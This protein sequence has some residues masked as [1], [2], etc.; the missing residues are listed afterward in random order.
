MKPGTTFFPV[1]SMT[2]APPRAAVLSTK[3]SPIAKMRSPEIRISARPSG[4]RRED[5]AASNHREECVVSHRGHA[6]IRLHVV[7]YGSP[8]VGG[9]A[10]AAP[11]RERS[12]DDLDARENDDRND[13]EQ[14][15]D[16]RQR[17]IDLVAHALP[18]PLGSVVVAGPAE[19]DRQH[20]LVE[21]NEEG[22]R[23]PRDHRGQDGGQRDVPERPEVAGAQAPRG[24]LDGRIG[25]LERRRDDHDHE[26][27]RH[28]GVARG[29][30]RAA[31]PPA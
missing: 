18:H 19:E 25:G 16:R 12:P 6:E 11:G 5:L 26:R 22:E 20:H 9:G 17:R 1:A 21:G 23:R 3:P 4:F 28:D 29:R 27:R 30:A 13:D 8:S 31:G 2:R 15:R 10:G 24:Q 7:P 14:R